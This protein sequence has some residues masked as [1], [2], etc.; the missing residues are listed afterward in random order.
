MIVQ[1]ETACNGYIL[2]YIPG[3]NDI[4]ETTSMPIV[5][6]EPEGIAA[7]EAFCTQHL[8]FQLMEMLGI[9]NSRKKY[10]VELNIVDGDGKEVCQ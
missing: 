9:E 10:H 4:D 6:E 5:I 3:E 1:I 8:L 7:S 2:R